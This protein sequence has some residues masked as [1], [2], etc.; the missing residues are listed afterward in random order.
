MSRRTLRIV[1]ML[2]LLSIAG[3]LT[4]QVFWFQRAYTLEEKQFSH[5]VHL[6]LQNTADRLLEY[7]GHTSPLPDPVDQLSS[8]YFIVMVN[9]RIDANLLEFF[10][11]NEFRERNITTDFEYG[12]YDCNEEQMVYGNF[13]KLGTADA[14]EPSGSLPQL[15]KENYYFGVYFPRRDV[16]LLSNLELWIVSSI[17]LLTVSAFFGYAVIALLRHRRLSEIQNDFVN[18]MTHEFKTPVSSI[19]VAAETLKR[20]SMTDPERIRRYADIIGTEAVKIQGQVERVL[21]IADP[22]GKGFTVKPVPTDIHELINEV[23][24]GFRSKFE[25]EG[26]RLRLHFN[27]DDC[28]LMVDPHH[29]Q[30]VLA[31]LLENALKYNGH[32]VKVDLHTW[33]DRRGFYVAVNDNGKAIPEKHRSRIFEKFYR[34]PTGDRHDVKGFGLG[35]YYVKQVMEAHNG[36]AGVRSGEHE[37]NGFTLFFRAK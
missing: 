35:L 11:Q 23:A 22:K 10:L 18:N 20:S 4:V 29:I 7:N 17:L 31:N 5:N 32:G 16:F 27:A 37:G 21:Q 14:A 8:S 33:R 3:I 24:G 34:I 28:A 30:N 2:G 19:T 13:V 9:D 1:V 15:D 12:I 25:E 26:G 36:K 6:A